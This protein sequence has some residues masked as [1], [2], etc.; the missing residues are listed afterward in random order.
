MTSQ[1]TVQVRVTHRFHASPE[2]VFDAWLD[3]ET[4][5]KWLFATPSGQMVR[6]EIDAR[7]GGSFVFV[8]RRN[9]EEIEHTGEYHEI[10]R[11]QRLVFTFSV[12]KFS[13][14]STRVTLDLVP[15]ATR[16]RTHPDPRRRLR[17]LREPHRAGLDRHTRRFG[18]RTIIRRLRANAER[19]WEEKNLL[20]ELRR[21]PWAKG[22]HYIEY[23]DTEW[24]VPVHDDRLLFEFLI[25]EGAQAGL[26]WDTILKKAGRNYRDA[27]D[28][29]DP[30]ARG[31][32]RQTGNNKVCSATRGS[33]AIGSRSN[34][35]SRTLRRTSRF[36]E[37][38][39]LLTNTSGALSPAG[40]GKAFGSR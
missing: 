19:K 5:G 35:P 36:N 14:D 20:G 27:F 1:P 6:V 26:S 8:D 38:S 24:G 33:S 39:A 21:C 15:L 18:Q 40:R 13:S 7:D 28:Q 4:A 22:Q 25:L 3:A 30:T 34:R 32:V 9:G 29:F 31:P 11:P 16:M 2:Q 17:R 23:H 37:S 12:P 10:A